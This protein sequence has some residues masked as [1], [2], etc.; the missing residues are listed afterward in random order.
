MA[1]VIRSVEGRILV[2]DHAAELRFAPPDEAMLS[3]IS[4]AT[5][6]VSSQADDVLRA[7]RSAGRRAISLRLAAG[8]GARCG[9]SI[10]FCGDFRL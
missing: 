8:A 7:P 2:V 4:R 1:R 6:G 9:P 5:G 10:S 3:A